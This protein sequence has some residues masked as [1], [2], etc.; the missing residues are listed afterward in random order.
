MSRVVPPSASVE[1]E[2]VRAVA[3]AAGEFVALLMHH[4]R[5]LEPSGAVGEREVADA[6][7]ELGFEGYA[8][9]LGR[10]QSSQEAAAARAVLAATEG[11]GAAA[12]GGGGGGGGG[13]EGGGEGESA[14]AE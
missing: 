5:S 12:G 13:G 11:L 2:A 4:A 8:H 10:W 9:R 3:C 6:L 14:M 7:E 1:V